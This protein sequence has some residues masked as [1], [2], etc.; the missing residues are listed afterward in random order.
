M[1][2]YS[3]LLGTVATGASMVLPGID[4]FGNFSM[5]TADITLGLQLLVPCCLLNLAIMVPDYSSWKVPQEPS[6]EAQQKMAESLVAWTAKR[7]AAADMA[8]AAA[9]SSS[10]AADTG[11]AAEAASSS[12]GSSGASDSSSS[13][14]SDSSS[15]SSTGDTTGRPLPQLSASSSSEGSSAAGS[16]TEVGSLLLPGAS[17]P[18]LVNNPDPP[19][20]LPLARCKDALLMA[21]VITQPP[22]A[23]AQLNGML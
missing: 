9:P 12:G 6:L 2:A 19:L 23:Q 21:Q 15:S 1:L 14:T 7:K 11:H 4:L 13:S 22:G 17:P 16:G 18:W 3:G 10:Q 20:P 5:N 8:A